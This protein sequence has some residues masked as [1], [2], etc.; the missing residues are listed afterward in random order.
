MHTAD[1]E[2]IDFSNFDSIDLTRFDADLLIMDLVHHYH[3]AFHEYEPENLFL[4]IKNLLCGIAVFYNDS[5]E[6]LDPGYGVAEA[7]LYDAGYF[8]VDKKLVSFALDNIEFLNSR[9]RRKLKKWKPDL[10]LEAFSVSIALFQQYGLRLDATNQSMTDYRSLSMFLLWPSPQDSES[11]QTFLSSALQGI[12][13][14]LLENN[15]ISE[16]ERFLEDSI[17][18]Q[19]MNHHARQILGD[20]LRRQKKHE[21]AIEQYREA[22]KIRSSDPPVVG[23]DVNT[24][25]SDLAEYNYLISLCYKE[26]HKYELAESHFNEA[27]E[28][29]D[30]SNYFGFIYDGFST[31]DQYGRELR[32]KRD[33]FSKIGNPT[34]EDYV[35]IIKSI[36]HSMENVL[37]N[38]KKEMSLIESRGFWNR[39]HP[40]SKEFLGSAE[41]LF[42]LFPREADFSPCIIQFCKVVESELH[43][44]FV[45]KLQAIIETEKIQI[46]TNSTFRKRSSLSKITLGGIVHILKDASIKNGIRQHLPINEGFILD[47][48]PDKIYDILELRNS[49][50]HIHGAT[51]EQALGVREVLFNDLLNPLT[52]I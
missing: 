18:R 48:L 31:L 10:R 17:Q 36:E 3:E 37:E 19:P 50:A 29:S 22:I 6:T 45:P 12:G 28:R 49:C 33:E 4:Y 11:E 9:T 7:I 23:I 42:N 5:Y 41:M 24:K 40:Q 27:Q 25:D 8:S 39:M 44:K 47:V 52:I 38:H 20:C 14:K 46:N 30:G 32:N 51:P 13:Y 43:N 2:F 21:Q 15:L 1:T 16:S 35:S 34:S 26:L